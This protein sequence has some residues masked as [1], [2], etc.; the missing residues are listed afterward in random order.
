MKKK[1]VGVYYESDDSRWRID[2]EGDLFHLFD[3]DGDVVTT[4][5]SDQLS[6]LAEFFSDILVDTGAKEP[7]QI[8][9]TGDGLVSTV[10]RPIDMRFHPD[11][12]GV[13]GF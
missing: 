9:N 13:M 6:T 1:F 7:V 11:P 3:R 2:V 5:S 8:A 4:L 12:D 10:T